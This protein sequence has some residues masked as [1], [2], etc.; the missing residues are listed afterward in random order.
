MLCSHHPANAQPGQSLEHG[1]QLLARLLASRPKVDVRPVARTLETLR[2]KKSPGE[3]DRIRRAVYISAE[4][5]RQAMLATEPRMNE[6]E[7]KALVEYNFLRYG[8]DGPAYASIVGSGPNSTTLHYNADNRCMNDG[9]VLLFDVARVFR[10]LRVQCHAH[11]SHQRQV[12]ARAARH[13]RDRA[14]RAEGGGSADQEVARAG[15]S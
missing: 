2:A 13:L 3:L 4:A 9:E 8:G 14:G 7:I 1:E 5:H 15:P 11:D 10:R 12:H 6:F